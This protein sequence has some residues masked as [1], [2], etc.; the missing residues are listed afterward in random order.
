LVVFFV[1]L[2]G[3]SAQQARAGASL[4]LKTLPFAAEAV[5]VAKLIHRCQVDAY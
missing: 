2:V 4:D 5:L 3:R 1:I